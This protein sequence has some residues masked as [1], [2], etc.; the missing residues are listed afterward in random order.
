MEDF[1]ACFDHDVKTIQKRSQKQALIYHVYLG[2]AQSTYLDS[3]CLRYR[4]HT[5]LGYLR[6]YSR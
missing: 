5:Y 2:M 1:E 4:V 3:T 6:Q